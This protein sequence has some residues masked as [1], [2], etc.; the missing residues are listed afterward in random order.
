[1]LRALALTTTVYPA[2]AQ[3]AHVLK[4]VAISGVFV[5]QLTRRKRSLIV[6]LATGGQDRHHDQGAFRSLYPITFG[7]APIAPDSV[8]TMRSFLL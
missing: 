3:L 6:E 5:C 2:M 1:M 4:A 8:R 7:M